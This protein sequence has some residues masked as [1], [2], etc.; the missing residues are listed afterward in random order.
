M[1][2]GK[3]LCSHSQACHDRDPEG[4]HARNCRA[5]LCGC[6]RYRAATVGA[7]AEAWLAARVPGQGAATSEGAA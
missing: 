6:G 3:C 4:K 1:N 7:E 2:T 5:P